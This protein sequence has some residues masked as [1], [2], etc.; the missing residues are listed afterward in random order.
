MDLPLAVSTAYRLGEYTALLVLLVVLVWCLRRAIGAPASSQTGPPIDLHVEAPAAPSPFAVG[1]SVAPPGFVP[2]PTVTVTT[3]HAAEPPN[4]GARSVRWPYVVGACVAAAL[5]FGGVVR[6]AASGSASPWDTPGGAAMKS[7][8]IYGC[9]R[10]AGAV[11]DCK[12]VFAHLTSQAPYDTPDGFAS[13]AG[14]VQTFERTGDRAAIPAV[15]GISIN[16]C[17]RNS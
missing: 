5:P 11:V 17:R 6:A 15:Y 3:G 1:S 10:T 2:A 16:A 9:S 12:C 8:F 7:G 4:T 13:L 14:D